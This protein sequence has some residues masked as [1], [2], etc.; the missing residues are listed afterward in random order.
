MLTP[1]EFVIRKSATQAFGA[2]NL[3]GINKYAAG[4][5]IIGSVKG[6]FGLGALG[7]IKGTRNLATEGRTLAQIESEGAAAGGI[8]RKQ[9]DVSVG[10]FEKAK[11]VSLKGSLGTFRQSLTKDE[12]GLF[13]AIKKKSVARGALKGKGNVV[14]GLRQ[15]L[16][17]VS[18]VT[19]KEIGELSQEDAARF[20]SQKNVAD[21]RVALQAGI[22]TY[23]EARAA[24]ARLVARGGKA[25]GLNS[26]ARKTFG[27]KIVA[28]IP[29]IIA[30]AS[31][32]MGK[33]F[34]Y[35]ANTPLSSVLDTAGLNGLTGLLFE[36]FVKSASRDIAAGEQNAAFDI[37][38]GDVAKLSTLFSGYRNPTELKNLFADKQINSTYNKAVRSFGVSFDPSKLATFAKGGMASGTD[39]VPALLTPGEF[40]VNKKSALLSIRSQRKRLV[41]EILRT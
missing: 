13:D 1:G 29:G 15:K 30:S 23:D 22:S 4:G 6:T 31:V 2:G 9:F 21:A 20:L 7:G 17:K 32:G 19:Q 41:M 5:K 26:G 38:A 25:Y 39:T 34:A 36:A 33:E 3:A 16:A 12:K 18:G 28:K 27:R 35:E 10:A 24:S 40:V 11:G 14:K 37:M 8:L